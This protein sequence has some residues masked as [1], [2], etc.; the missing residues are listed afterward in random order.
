M[1]GVRDLRDKADECFNNNDFTNAHQN[2]ELLVETLLSHINDTR[3]IRKLAKCGGWLAALLTGG[4]GV[5]DIVIIP[6]VNRMLLK[7]LNVDIDK[8]LEILGYALRQKLGC[9]VMANGL[10]RNVDYRLQLKYFIITYMI[11][12][13]VSEA[14]TDKLKTLLDLINPVSDGIDLDKIEKINSENEIADVLAEQIERQIAQV[15]RLNSY[16]FAF[17]YKVGQTNN[18]LFLRLQSKGYTI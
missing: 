8:L 15:E 11:S 3:T 4:F 6:A 9:L 1:E 7:L 14:R 17:L 16:L 18:P 13:K 10:A 2:Y 12:A 5:E